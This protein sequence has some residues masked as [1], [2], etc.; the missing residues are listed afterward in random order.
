MRQSLN[1]INN[2]EENMVFLSGK[3][4]YSDHFSIL[5]EEKNAQISSVVKPQKKI[6]SFHFSINM[7]IQFLLDQT[8]NVEGTFQ[9]WIL[10]L[11]MEGGE[12]G[13]LQQFLVRGTF[14]S[15]SRPSHLKILVLRI[16]YFLKVQFSKIKQ[17]SKNWVTLEH[18]RNITL[19]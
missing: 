13:Q 6:I 16:L 9:N 17:F 3:M 12:E 2:M 15:F 18:K 5:F 8:K 10:S 19:L 11:S 4:L 1:L 7:D 14:F